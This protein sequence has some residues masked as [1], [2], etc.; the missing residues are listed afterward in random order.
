M[1]YILFSEK[2]SKCVDCNEYTYNETVPVKKGF[3][4][5]WTDQACQKLQKME[6]YKLIASQG[7][8][9]QIM[10]EIF[11]VK[12]PTHSLGGKELDGREYSEVIDKMR[13]GLKNS[14][15]TLSIVRKYAELLCIANPEFYQQDDLEK[16]LNESLRA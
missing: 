9:S 15:R 14:K 6:G 13:S 16:I 4:M 10:R 11:N 3:A 5:A 12:T 1:P 7:K 8:S 2:L